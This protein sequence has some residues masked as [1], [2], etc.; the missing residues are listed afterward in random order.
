MADDRSPSCGSVS[1]GAI[2][3]EKLMSRH[4][5][6]SFSPLQNACSSVTLVFWP[7]TITVRLTTTDF[8][9]SPLTCLVLIEQL[10]PLLCLRRAEALGHPIPVSRFLHVGAH[11]HDTELGK[12]ARI[13]SR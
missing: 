13:V 10:E 9:R 8:M 4:A 11:P 2:R 12:H 5:A 7:A 1:T 3:S 6:P